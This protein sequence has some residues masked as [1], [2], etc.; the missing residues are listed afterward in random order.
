MQE[1]VAGG[2][3]IAAPHKVAAFRRRSASGRV[4]GLGT[5]DPDAHCL[6]CCPS[7]PW[8][9]THGP[10]QASR[11]ARFEAQEMRDGMS[12]RQVNAAIAHVIRYEPMTWQQGLAIGLSSSC[13][14]VVSRALR[15]HLEDIFPDMRAV[16]GEDDI[17][18]N[19]EDAYP[20][21]Y[22]EGN[23][24]TTQPSPA[25]G[26]RATPG[27]GTGS[28]TGTGTGGA[29]PHPQPSRSCQERRQPSDQRH[30]DPAPKGR[31]ARS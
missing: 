24:G 10:G 15:R 12:P 19:P 25:P 8:S 29:G 22:P 31:G 6:T 4:H 17:G 7:V 23:M 30:D 16:E 28:D 18:P 20:P 9:L 2:A 27:T 11:L 21:V 1:G 5:H 13:P 14:Q 26:T 3:C